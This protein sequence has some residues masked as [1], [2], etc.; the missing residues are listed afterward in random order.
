MKQIFENWNRFCRKERSADNRK[1]L[2][3]QYIKVL[4][5]VSYEQSKAIRQF[6]AQ[7]GPY[8]YSFDDLFDGKMRLAFPLDTD[9]AKNLKTVI[10]AIRKDGYTIPGATVV[11]PEEAVFNRRRVKQKRRRLGT[12]EEYEIEITV[13]DIE[14]EKIYDFT[15]PAGPRKGES[16]QKTDKRGIAKLMQKLIKERKLD[17]NLL[18]WWQRRQTYYTKDNNY[19]EIEN[20]MRGDLTNYMVILTRHPIDVLRMSDIGAIESC[21]QSRRSGSSFLSLISFCMSLAI[22]RLSVF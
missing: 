8:D 15:I 3:E 11:R 19:V 12:G 17:P 21:H 2:K 18:D 5:E 22:P 1:L 13:A 7:A 20:L 4:N 10:T 9:D 6:I 14:F 16:I